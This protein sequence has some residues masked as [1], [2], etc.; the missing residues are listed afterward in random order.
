[1]RNSN[2]FKIELKRAFKSR[3]L[4]IALLAGMIIAVW[5]YVQYVLPLIRAE[6]FEEE[7]YY[8]VTVFES[9]MGGNSYTLQQY[10]LFIIFP[11]LA[12]LPF[13]TSYYEDKK[14]GEYKNIVTRVEKKEYI[15]AKY[16]AV[17]LSAGVVTL[18]PLVLS[19]LLTSATLPSLLPQAATYS[20]QIH[21]TNFGHQL[22]FTH[23]Y[24]Y[25]ILYLVFDFIFAGA[26][27]G[28]ALAASTFAGNICIVLAAPFVTGMF[29]MVM[30]NML[31]IG[32]YAPVYFL[33]P[34]YGMENPLIPLAQLA[35]L[36]IYVGITFII[37]EKNSE[38][39]FGIFLFYYSGFTGSLSVSGK[40]FTA[41][42][43]AWKYIGGRFL[44]YSTA[45]LYLGVHP[46][47]VSY[48]IFYIIYESEIIG[49][50]D[51]PV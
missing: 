18:F 48:N 2:I 12:V 47:S 21:N 51:Y 35:I 49:V 30:M 34:G 17:F 31:N 8:P 37:G 5:H 39:L 33:N 14:S 10:L 41:Y 6:E 50:K 45:V 27:A 23:P 20:F 38:D 22:F 15:K 46:Y 36:L 32:K 11:I 4:L 16:K 44:L 26:F 13:G 25:I 24:L 42:G 28:I 29:L 9:W 1:M 3:K 40:S 43:L 7:I 19:L